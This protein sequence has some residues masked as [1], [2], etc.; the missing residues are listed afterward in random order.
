MQLLGFHS[1]AEMRKRIQRKH[2][3]KFEQNF[4]NLAKLEKKLNIVD[5]GN[6]KP[7]SSIKGNYQAL[8]DIVEYFNELKITSYSNWRK[9]GFK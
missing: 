5:F 8:R 4:I 7:A 2:R 6:L 9:P 1:I 3:I